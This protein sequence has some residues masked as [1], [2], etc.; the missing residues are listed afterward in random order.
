MTSILGIP[1]NYYI[2]H[3]QYDYG[4]DYIDNVYLL[5]IDGKLENA[6]GTKEQAEQFAREHFLCAGEA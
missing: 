2:E 3:K 4:C 6:F 5:Y 1:A